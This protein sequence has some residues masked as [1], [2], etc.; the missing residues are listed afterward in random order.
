[1]R[2]DDI[3]RLVA[4]IAPDAGPGLT[5]GARE[6]M[7]GIAATHPAPARRRPFPVPGLRKIHRALVPL[8][9]AAVLLTWTLPAEVAFGP[10]P[11]NALEIRRAGV[12]FA[13]AVRDVYAGR[14]SYR[15]ELTEVGLRIS[16]VVVPGAP[17]AVGQIVVVHGGR[18]SANRYAPT[19]WT[20][21]DGYDIAPL[22]TSAYC[23]REEDCPIG[24][25][26]RAGHRGT[27]TVWVAR[28]ARPGEAYLFPRT[29]SAPPR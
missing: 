15:R 12:F 2:T 23:V 6:L 20:V 18:L 7:A 16:M 1:M 25:R 10:R 8:A 22:V 11:A 19:T 29:V 3:D 4:S 13:I 5:P 26:I 21:P 9:L 14:E 28:E 17:G 27:E 24:L